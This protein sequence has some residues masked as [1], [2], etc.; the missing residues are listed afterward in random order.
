MSK[1]FEVASLHGVTLEALCKVIEA[2]VNDGSYEWDG[3]W[4]Q[5]SLGYEA[6]VTRTLHRHTS[7]SGGPK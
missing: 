1:K 6:V 5:T 4:N 2:H 7:Q 3:R